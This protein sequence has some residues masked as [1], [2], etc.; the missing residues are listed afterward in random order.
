MNTQ[1][2]NPAKV[3]PYIIAALIIM[4]ALLFA[5]TARSQT[6]Q[7]FGSVSNVLTGLGVGPQTA[8]GVSTTLGW[9]VDTTPYITNGNIMVEVGAL[10]LGS[11]WGGLMDVQLPVNTNSWQITYG[12]AAAYLNRTIYTGALN[13]SLGTTVNVPVLSSLV[14][15]FYAYA[16]SGPGW[17]FQKNQMVAQSFVGVKYYHPFTSTFGLG[18]S[19]GYGTITDVSGG[20]QSFTG[21]FTLKL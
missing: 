17:N 15:P 5:T 2:E 20:I 18:A 7:T 19:Y 6:N 14:G 9:L 12:V 3:I 4:A 16:E 10:K 8:Q 13:V 11:H 21:L 1:T